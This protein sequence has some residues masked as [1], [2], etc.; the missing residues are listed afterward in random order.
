MSFEE[1]AASLSHDEIVSLLELNKTYQQE[2]EQKS[3]EFIEYQE[4][5]ER[6]LSAKEVEISELKQRLTWYQKQI[7]GKKSEKRILTPDMNQLSLGEM[8][9]EEKPPAP[10]TTVKEYQ[11]KKGKKQ[12][13]EDMPD[14]TGLRFDSNVP[15]EEIEVNNPEI[16][17]LKPEEYESIEEKHTYRLAQRPGAYVVLKYKRKVVKLKESKEI[18]TTSAPDAVLERSYADVSLLAGINIDKFLYHIPLFRQHQRMQAA[19]IKLSRATLTNWVQRSINL[20]VPVYHAQLSSILLSQVLA[21][22]ETPVKAGRKEKGKMN[23]AYFWPI[24]GDKDEIAFMFSMSRG[25]ELIRKV[26]KDFCGTLISDGY[27]VYD[28][29]TKERDKI[30]LAQCWVHARRKFIDAENSEPGLVAE[31]LS[32]IQ[33]LYEIE[34]AINQKS[35]SGIEKLEY[36]VEYSKPLVDDYFIWLNAAFQKNILLPS[37]PFTAAANY[38]LKR[39]DELKVFLSNPNVPLDTNH[40]ERALRPIPMGRKNWLFCWT[41]LGARDVGIIQSLLQTCKLQGIDPYTYLVDVLQ[42]VD[43]H[44]IQEIDKLTPRLWKEH[45]SANPLRS[46]LY[47]TKFNKIYNTAS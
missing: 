21:M 4:Q 15:V 10:T 9:F 7:F 42:R 16:D 23:T 17:N 31:V 32:R 35:L 45:F 18:V 44:P 38:T 5:K 47:N 12:R 2:I 43:T 28:N 33:K 3:T 40:L 41:E 27:T 25:A 13:I 20:L 39:E 19:G 36:R 34:E 6:E 1:Q 26:L 11:R 22:D 30:T 24:Y 14:D 46:D 29:F 8:H 37:N